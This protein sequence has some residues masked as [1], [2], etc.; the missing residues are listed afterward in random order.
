MGE[1][2]RSEQRPE[3][4][5]RERESAM[6]NLGERTGRARAKAL[7]QEWA[8]SI[9]GCLEQSEQ[10]RVVAE[11]VSEVGRNRSEGQC[12]LMWGSWLPF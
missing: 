9:P 5:E 8:R 2:D 7:G 11:E 12:G 4:G 3:E 1:I 6:E 10:G